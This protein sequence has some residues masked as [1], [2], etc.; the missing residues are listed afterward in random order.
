MESPPLQ[1]LHEM[2]TQTVMCGLSVTTYIGSL[3]RKIH[4]LQVQLLRTKKTLNVV[5]TERDNYMTQRGDLRKSCKCHMLAPNQLEFLASQ[6]QAA[7]VPKK[8]MRW[9][10]ADKSHALRLMLKSPAAY[11]LE[12]EQWRLPHKNTLL[13]LVRPLYTEV[14]SN[15][16][17]GAMK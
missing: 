17:L 15:R 8:L 3:R 5:R 1:H 4:S 6:A 16:R 7:A 9:T 10:C 2:S 12:Q 11:R 13:R 14:S